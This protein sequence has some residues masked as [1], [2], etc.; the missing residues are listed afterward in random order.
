M[1]WKHRYAESQK[2]GRDNPVYRSP[3]GPGIYEPSALFRAAR[4]DALDSSKAPTWAL[5]DTD[6]KLVKSSDFE[7]KV[8]LLDFWATWCAPC[9]AEIPGFIEL[10][11]KYGPKGLVVVGVSLDER[12]PSRV[13]KFMEDFGM[14]YPVVMGNFKLMEQFGGTAIP[15]TFVIDRSGKIVAKHVGFATKETFERDIAPLL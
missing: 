8:V 15:T 9:K 12:G 4:V 5:K 1:L 11:Q 2:S 7:G 14:N 3:P 10:Q 13:R 6:G